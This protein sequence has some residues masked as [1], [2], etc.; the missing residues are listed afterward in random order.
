MITDK[1][2]SLRCCWSCRYCKY[3]LA[4]G[5]GCYATGEGHSHIGGNEAIHKNKDNCKLYK[6]G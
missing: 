1:D 6:R 4:L 2:F 3:D 5:Y